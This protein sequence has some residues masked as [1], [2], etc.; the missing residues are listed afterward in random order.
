MSG[1]C[2]TE[3]VENSEEN[4]ILTFVPLW[5][6]VYME[7]CRQPCV[8]LCQVAKGPG[9]KVSGIC[10][11]L[12][13]MELFTEPFIIIFAFALCL[14]VRGTCSMVYGSCW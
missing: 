7:L 8:K 1:G 12:V 10:W 4:P 9:V 3:V 13:H 2:W 5:I 11:T 14:V 6:K